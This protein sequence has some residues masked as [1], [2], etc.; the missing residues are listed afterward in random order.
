M[1]LHY[2]P[3]QVLRIGLKLA[4]ASK[5]QQERRLQ[6]TNIK[7]FKAIYGTEPVVC[8]KIWDDLQTTNIAEAKIDATLYDGANLKNFLR[9]CHFLMRYK[10]ET[11]RKLD[12]GHTK[13]TIRKWTWFFLAKIKALK[14]AKVGQ[15]PPSLHRKTSFCFSL[16]FL[17][18]HRL[19]GPTVGLPISS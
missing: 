9:S 3:E 16:F 1:I 15:K 2:T 8:A 10:T 19:F 11:E 14:A 17:L 7:D 4:G 6:K 5:Q 18:R 13:K 12:S